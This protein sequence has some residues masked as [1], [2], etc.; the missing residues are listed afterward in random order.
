M[1]TNGIEA[2]MNRPTDIAADSK[3]NYY[4]VETGGCQIKKFDKNLRY[5]KSFGHR[6]K[7][8]GEFI[9]PSAIFIAKNDRVY[10]SDDNLSKIMV[11]NVEGKYLEAISVKGHELYF[12]LLKNGNILLPNPVVGYAAG[13]KQFSLLHILDTDGKVIQKFGEGIIYKTFPAANGGNRFRFDVDKNGNIIISFLFQNRIEKYDNTGRLR[14][15]IKR[16]ILK[17]MIIDKKE[18]LYYALSCGVSFDEKGRIWNLERVKRPP[19]PDRKTL[20]EAIINEDGILR[21]DKNKLDLPEKTDQYALDL[22]NQDGIFLYRY[23]L[24]H[25]CSNLRIIGDKL[26]VCDIDLTMDFYVYQINEKLSQ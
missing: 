1:G 19:R 13:A 4:V 20:E 15:S 8:P 24:D 23:N 18:N 25:Y 9:T 11:Y 21:I 26:F 14:M 2:F 7:G 16:E 10:V 12:K 5:V 22:Y 17:E 6:G 3:G